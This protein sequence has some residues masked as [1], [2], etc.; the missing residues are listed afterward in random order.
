MMIL[1]AFF[2]MRDDAAKANRIFNRIICMNANGFAGMVPIGRVPEVSQ[3]DGVLA[4]SPFSWYGGKYHDE[5]M[6][7]AQ[8]S[9]DANT[10]FKVLDEFTVPADQLADFQ[11]NKDGAAIGRRLASD[12]GLKVGD[13]LPL[14]GRHLSRRHGPDGP[15]HL[16]RPLQPQ[17]A[18]VPV[19]L[20]L[21]RRGAQEGHHELRVGRLAFHQQ[22][23]GLRQR[24][25]DLHQVQERRHH[26]RP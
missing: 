11:A 24:G 17:P 1:L 3:L 5:V 10:V 2:D 12:R 26:A 16:R 9:V 19:P 21:P 15:G 7:F 13:P 8:F 18:D 25:H 23:P 22:L 4:A 6:P 14:E 20:R